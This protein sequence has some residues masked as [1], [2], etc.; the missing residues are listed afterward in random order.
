MSTDFITRSGSQV[1]HYAMFDIHS[2][3]KPLRHLAVRRGKHIGLPITLFDR[4]KSLADLLHQA[5]GQLAMLVRDHW[6]PNIVR[7][8]EFDGEWDFQPAHFTLFATPDVRAIRQIGHGE[9]VPA[10][11]DPSDYDRL[12]IPDFSIERLRSGAVA[13]VLA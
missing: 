7:T 11:I 6:M 12:G 2:R 3:D 4:N 1:R 10:T 13:P 9:L 5:V 8:G